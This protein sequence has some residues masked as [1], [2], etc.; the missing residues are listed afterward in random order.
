MFFYLEYFPVWLTS[1]VAA[2]MPLD[3]LGG[4]EGR[5][6]IRSCP[7]GIHFMPA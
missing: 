4:F 3:K 1:R 7:S 2:A 5:R 6:G